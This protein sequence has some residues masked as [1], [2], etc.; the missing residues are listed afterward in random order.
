MLK[1]LVQVDISF[2][3]LHG[4]TPYEKFLQID[5]GGGGGFTCTEKT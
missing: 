1:N 5:I 2:S 3:G 4:N